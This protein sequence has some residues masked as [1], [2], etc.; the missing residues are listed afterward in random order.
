[1]QVCLYNNLGAAIKPFWALSKPNVKS[2]WRTSNLTKWLF[3]RS[4]GCSPSGLLQHVLGV[5]CLLWALTFPTSLH[6]YVNNKTPKLPPNTCTQVLCRP[7]ENTL[8]IS[9]WET[10]CGA[11]PKCLLYA[12]LCE[13]LMY[14]II[15]SPCTHLY[16]IFLCV[17]N[18]YLKRPLMSTSCMFLMSLI[19]D[20]KG[21]FCSK[22]VLKWHKRT[23]M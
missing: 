8:I 9:Y 10:V 21:I 13:E 11:L 16:N 3:P 5:V 1:M 2:M 12:S 22:Y 18:S 6:R 15:F 14:C 4:N 19:K 7:R 23:H 17:C 20:N